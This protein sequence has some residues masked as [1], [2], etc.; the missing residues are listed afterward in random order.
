MAACSTCR[1]PLDSSPLT[2]NCG[3]DCLTCMAMCGDP[4]CVTGLAVELAKSLWNRLPGPL[5]L[6]A[7]EA[8]ALHVLASHDPS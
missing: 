5:L 7:E 8:R 4:E 6:S 1:G 2:R 3:G